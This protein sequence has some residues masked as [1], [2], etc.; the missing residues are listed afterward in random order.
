MDLNISQGKHQSPP[1]WDAK[2]K[3]E[4]E[5]DTCETMHNPFMP[6]STIRLPCGAQP[7]SSL[8]T[9]TPEDRP[10]E[11]HQIISLSAYVD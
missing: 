1:V 7:L 2:R 10:K 3:E 9:R 8:S 5:T 6:L 11:Q 4:E